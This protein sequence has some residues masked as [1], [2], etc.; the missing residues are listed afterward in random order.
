MKQ[1]LLYV[2]VGGA[3][4]IA[5]WLCFFVFDKMMHYFGAVSLAF[6]VSTFVNWGVGRLILF[7]SKAGSFK[8]ELAQIY[9]VSI[10]GLLLNLLIMYLAVERFGVAE[11]CS[12]M[13]GTGVVFIWNFLIRKLV[14]YKM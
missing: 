10:V 12:K 14:I 5:E 1:F 7:K 3:A 13:I 6:A 4:T 9:S 2:I 8:K 11:M